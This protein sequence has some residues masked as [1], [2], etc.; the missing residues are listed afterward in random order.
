[1]RRISIICLMLCACAAGAAAQDIWK[2]YSAP[3]VEREDVFAFAQKPSVKLLS[4]D[5]YRITFAVKGYCD[6]TVGIVDGKGRVV[7][8]LGSGV[9][10]R[11]AP[12][13]FQENSLSQTIIW[14]GK[15]DM[16]RYPDHPE[17]LCVRVM[18]GLKPV[19][20]KRVGGTSGKDVPGSGIRGIAIGPDGAYV[21]NTEGNFGHA[22]LRKYDRNGSYVCSLAPPPRG[23]PEEKLTGQYVVEYEPGKRA[24]QGSDIENMQQARWLVGLGNFVRSVQ[25]ALAGDRFVW[26]NRGFF[27]QTDSKLHY[28]HTDGSTD[29]PGLDGT[30]LAS[31][32]TH[33]HPRLAA[34]PDGKKVYATIGPV[35]KT[36]G[37]CVFV[38]TLKAGSTATV[39][40]GDRKKPGTDNR[41]LQDARG[42]DCDAQGRLHV[43]DRG[44]N[45]IQ[46]FSPEG[47]HVKTI[48]IERPSWVFV[49]RK[50][51]AIYVQH[52]A[53]VKGRTGVR[54][55]KLASLEN[56]KEVFHWEAFPA[57]MALDSWSAKP[58]LW[59]GDDLRRRDPR[60]RGKLYRGKEG[61]RSAS[62]WEERDNTFVKIADLY[63][64]GKKEGGESWGGSWS[65]CGP[66]ITGA[67][68]CD[69]VREKLYYHSGAGCRV[70]DLKTGAY[71]YWAGLE[72]WWLDIAFDKRGF[73]HCHQRAGRTG[74]EAYVFRLDPDR[75]KPHERGRK[76][77]LG[78]PVMVYAECPYDY[79]VPLGRW[80][81]V[82]HSRGQHGAN[83]FQHGLGVTMQGDIGIVARIFYQPKMDETSYEM[84]F[85]GYLVRKRA[86]DYMGS[87]VWKT[88]EGYTRMILDRLKKGE[89]LF[90]IKRRPGIPLTGC[91]IWTY[92]RTGECRKSLAVIAGDLV[93]GTQL[94]EDGSLYFVTARPKLV[95][96]KRFLS[97]TGERIGDPK[98]P[99][100][101]RVFTGTLVKTKPGAACR[102]MYEKA[103]V[104][105]DE[106]PKR[107]P[108]LGKSAGGGR[109][110]FWAEG[111]EW[112]YGGA[113]PIVPG[114]CICYSM[115]VY[116]DWYKR[117]H[118][119]EGYRHSVGILD[120]NG[121]LIM[122]LGRYANFDSAPGGRDGCR[123][124][125]TDIGMTN[126]RYV[127]GTDNYLAF[128][129]W[130]ERIVVLRLEYH[131]EE[132][133]GIRTN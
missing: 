47:K 13:P 79:G 56:P 127:G 67:V 120:T 38:S 78:R 112:T 55:T 66:T 97:G 106:A 94:D 31:R 26:A 43:A 99:G 90:S 131:A 117:V 21:L 25:P 125:G 17:K 32:E 54:V 109:Q 11:N 4:K 108:D 103:T 27:R 82:I 12:A 128:E 49:H 60:F 5:R 75:A 102:I 80:V 119:P 6:V 118:V 101:R 37:T 68:V 65:G 10:G 86:G 124:G 44:N 9:L 48:G 72:N 77:Q 96:G 61:P 52:E 129:D 81:G 36:S 50:T 33:E 93:N 57:V 46:V 113:S 7:R 8:H 28:I 18:L 107:P 19:F 23:L 71:E 1:M 123:S 2:P 98:H 24:L 105:M 95:G 85:A 84:A 35:K 69:P 114:G 89:E 59:V 121:N 116:V 63:E 22:T 51:G 110:D 41:H 76:D 115:R 20:D 122:H 100:G 53:R 133:V 16:G 104:P 14:N 92:D 39:F 126:V 30:V 62:I 58:R 40:V 111:A 87:Q 15:D 64:E 88:Y 3:C 34:S 70:F 45:R 130:G 42:L 132:T 73:L 83:G 91:T 29:V 74:H